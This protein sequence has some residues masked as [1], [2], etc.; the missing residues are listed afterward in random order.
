[1]G[2]KHRTA[3]SAG[4][5]GSFGSDGEGGLAGRAL[6]S[7]RE[8]S[9]VISGRTDRTVKYTETHVAAQARSLDSG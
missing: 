2:Q 9:E 4:R 1:M 8:W 6:D 3:D 5:R 7:A